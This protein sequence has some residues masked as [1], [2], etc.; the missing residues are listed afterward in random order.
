[1]QNP[2]KRTESG[3]SNQIALGMLKN[4]KKTRKNDLPIDNIFL[5]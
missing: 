5:L 4:A 3:V 1:M 2:K